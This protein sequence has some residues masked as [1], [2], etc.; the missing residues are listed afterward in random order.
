MSVD[1]STSDFWEWAS[2]LWGVTPPFTDPVKDPAPAPLGVT[3]VNITPR[4]DEP[5]H[6]H[7]GHDGGFDPDQTQRIVIAWEGEND[8]N[9][10]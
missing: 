4:T 7:V 9:R 2:V 1:Y 5:R 3:I 10:Q 6:P 8:E